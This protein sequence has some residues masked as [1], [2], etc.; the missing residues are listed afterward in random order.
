MAAL[1]AVVVVAF[2]LAVQQLLVKETLVA[3]VGAHQITVAGVVA[4]LVQ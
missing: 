2:I 1:E 3:V 4:V